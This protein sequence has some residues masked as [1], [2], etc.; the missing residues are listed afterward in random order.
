MWYQIFLNV[1]TMEIYE[2]LGIMK[3]NSTWK[4][5]NKQSFSL[6]E[7]SNERPSHYTSIFLEKQCCPFQSPKIISETLT[8]Q[9][10]FASRYTVN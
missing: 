3:D 1:W 5:Y 10:Y 6:L 2:K 7:C 8:P 9:V 4:F